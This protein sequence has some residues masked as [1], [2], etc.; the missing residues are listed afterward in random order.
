MRKGHGYHQYQNESNG[1][2]ERPEMIKIVQHNSPSYAPRTYVNAESADLTLAFAIDYHTAGE[3]LTMKAAG[4]RRF[5]MLPL[6]IDGQEFDVE[7]H[8]DSIIKKAR[9]NGHKEISVNIAGNGAYTLTSFKWEQDRVNR[10]ITSVLNAVNEIIP[11]N[12]IVS[13]GQTGADIAGAVAAR[14]LG[15]D[16]V[17]TMPKGYKQ[18]GKDSK[19]IDRNPHK[20]CSEIDAFAKGIMASNK[21]SSAINPQ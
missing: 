18:R 17:I 5:L 11:I 13:G 10:Y 4:T 20:I 21:P 1:L 8:V 12:K 9:Q 16:A 2:E 15:I 14:V 3:R 7:L 6:E 19:D